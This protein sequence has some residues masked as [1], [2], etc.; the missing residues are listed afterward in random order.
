VT[1]DALGSGAARLV[2]V[3][4]THIEFCRQVALGA[5]R[6]SCGAQLCTV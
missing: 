6:I 4:L 3:V 2:M 5:K 1:V